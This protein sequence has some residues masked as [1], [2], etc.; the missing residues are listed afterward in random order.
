MA[1]VKPL[2]VFI[3]RII[4]SIVREKNSRGFLA[5]KRRTVGLITIDNEECEKLLDS[6][7]INKG[8]VI[9]YLRRVYKPTLVKNGIIFK[10]QKCLQR[11]LIKEDGRVYVLIRN[12]EPHKIATDLLYCQELLET[13]NFKHNGEYTLVIEQAKITIFETLVYN[14]CLKEWG[15]VVP[16]AIRQEIRKMDKKYGNLEACIG[17]KKRSIKRKILK[18]F[19]KKGYITWND[20]REG[21]KVS[22]YDPR[23]IK[24]LC[25]EIRE[26]NPGCPV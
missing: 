22:D 4:Q 21:I 10:D 5:L 24:K 13:Y 9:T 11:V 12:S 1:E 18:Y 17:I 7:I 14:E 15:A 8:N 3:K 26:R 25:Q 16:F 6:F 2:S 23:N 20:L 19:V